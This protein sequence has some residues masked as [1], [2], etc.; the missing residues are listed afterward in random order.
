[1]CLFYT[2]SPGWLFPFYPRLLPAAGQDSWNIV[3]SSHPLSR[4]RQLLAV[5]ARSSTPHSMSMSIAFRPSSSLR[6]RHTI[7]FNLDARQ[8][9]IARMLPRFIPTRMSLLYLLWSSGG[10]GRGCDRHTTR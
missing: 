1:M 8:N 9:G 10:G 5:S 6:R 7:Y 2:Q 4:R 3:V